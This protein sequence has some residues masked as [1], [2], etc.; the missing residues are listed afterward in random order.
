M[1]YARATNSLTTVFTAISETTTS[2]IYCNKFSKEV[3][4]EIQL[5]IV[6]VG[7][8][9]WNV[10]IQGAFESNDIFVDNYIGCEGNIFRNSTGNITSGM[11]ICFKCLPPHFKIVATEID[12]ISTLTLKYEL[13]SKS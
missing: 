8:G 10:N 11:I 3:F 1:S 13:I 9:T 2:E 4:D 12:G 6:I 5:H 7:T